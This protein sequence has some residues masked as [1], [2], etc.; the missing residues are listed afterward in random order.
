MKNKIATFRN[1]IFQQKRCKLALPIAFQ[2]LLY[3]FL[4][5]VDVLML[6][7]LGE[8]EIAAVGLGNRVFFLTY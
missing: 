7:Q 6:S 3:S 8:T 1:P 4:G 2:S 5:L